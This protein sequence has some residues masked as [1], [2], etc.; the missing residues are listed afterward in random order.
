M[1]ATFLF[2]CGIIGIFTLIG[3]AI[4][5]IEAFTKYTMLN[6]FGCLLVGVF[7]SGGIVFANIASGTGNATIS[8]CII[9]LQTIVI[10]VF[11]YLVFD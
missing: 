4:Y 5:D 9:Q 8:N 6:Y 10:C 3:T 11:N 1:G 2:F 7:Q